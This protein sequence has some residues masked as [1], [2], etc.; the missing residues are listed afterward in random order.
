MG[1]E[2]KG[3]VYESGTCYVQ[4]TLIVTHAIITIIKLI[5]APDESLLWLTVVPTES[6]PKCRSTRHNIAWI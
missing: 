6:S 1:R 3:D 2:M 4:A 5:V